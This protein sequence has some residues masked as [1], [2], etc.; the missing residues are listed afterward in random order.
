MQRER[1]GAR[2]RLGREHAR[3]RVEDAV[4]RLDVRLGDL[5]AVDHR[6]ARERD[7]ELAAAERRQL[8]PLLEVAREEGAGDDVVLEDVGE[9][10]EVAQLELGR[11]ERLERAGKSVVVG[12][13]EREGARAGERALEA[14]RVEAGAERDVVRVGGDDP[15]D[16][17][18]K[19]LAA[20]LAALGGLRARGRGRGGERGVRDNV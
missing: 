17:A 20:L 3:D 18:V 1:R 13:E 9:R 8:L 4:G 5:D 6:A 15:V 2:Q 19:G 11:A 16:R 12:R 7:L 10:G 14:G